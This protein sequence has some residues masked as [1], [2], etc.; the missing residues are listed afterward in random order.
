[1]KKQK[2]GLPRITPALATLPVSSPATDNADPADTFEISPSA[3]L[4]YTFHV[5]PALTSVTP[6]SS[7][8][9][10]LLSSC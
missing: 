5:Q 3:S 9:A 1:M 7:V 6:D 4:P 2:S 10:S 8:L